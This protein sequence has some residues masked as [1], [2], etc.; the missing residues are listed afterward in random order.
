[1]YQRKA[2]ARR[3]AAGVHAEKLHAAVGADGVRTYC[4][5]HRVPHFAGPELERL[6]SSFYSSLSQL[7]VEDDIRGV[8]TY[9]AQDGDDILD[10]WLYRA[11]DKEVRVLNE[12]IVIRGAAVRRFATAVFAAHPTARRIVFNAVYPDL[13]RL[14]LPYQHWHSSDD[15]VLMLPTSEEAYLSRLGKA[16]RKNIKR[17]LQRFTQSFPSFRYDVYERDA[18]PEPLL[19][20]I[21]TLNRQRMAAKGKVSG[22][23]AQQEVRLLQLARRCGLIGVATVEGKV[24]AG[25]I[26]CRAGRD[27]F[28]LVRAHDPAYDDYRLGLVG[29]YH[30][31]QTCIARGGRAL[32]LMWGREPHKALLGGETHELERV[33]VFRSR[34]HA[35]LD[36]HLMLRN[37]SAARVHALKSRLLEKA[38]RG[39]GVL[40]RL[41]RRLW[42]A[43][44]AAHDHAGGSTSEAP[45]ARDE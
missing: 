44:R 16:T 41:L 33:I 14:P 8:S 21:V 31:V 10:L 4:H 6:Y 17:Y 25:A 3:R 42:M 1:M 28:S 43:R 37:A 15:S 27:Y 34:R 9:V 22:I 23:D 29:A 7:E 20:A 36:T 11:E 32:H 45:G 19:H 35:L 40:G 12:A 13:D 38:R 39:D 2:D 30:L 5:V 26:V 24:C 18:I